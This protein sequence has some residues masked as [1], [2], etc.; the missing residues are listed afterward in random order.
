MSAGNAATFVPQPGG[1]EGCIAG[2]VNGLGGC[3]GPVSYWDHGAA[4]VELYAQG[5]EAAEACQSSKRHVSLTSPPCTRL[6]FVRPF[7]SADNELAAF[8]STITPQL[9]TVTQAAVQSI[10]A[11]P[12]AASSAPAVPAVKSI[13]LSNEPLVPIAIKVASKLGSEKRTTVTSHDL[14]RHLNPRADTMCP[15]DL[16][17]SSHQ[18]RLRRGRTRRARRGGSERSRC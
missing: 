11:P 10:S 12:P 1:G 17:T 9:A 3:T 15:S 6:T 8:L 18:V 2:S 5:W 13:A 16:L 4:V 14:G 7:F